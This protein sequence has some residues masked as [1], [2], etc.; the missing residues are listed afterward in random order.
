M[1]EEARSAFVMSGRY[2]E[3]ICLVEGL[4]LEIVHLSL[5]STPRV[6]SVYAVAFADEDLFG[7]QSPLPP[8]GAQ[9]SRSFNTF[10]LSY[11]SKSQLASSSQDLQPALRFH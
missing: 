5:C 8:S 4:W 11:V 7:L 6:N 10:D 9:G 2:L 1:A 3:Q